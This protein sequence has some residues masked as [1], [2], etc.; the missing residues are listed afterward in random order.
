MRASV[1]RLPRNMQ[2]DLHVHL[3]VTVL[4]I[5][6]RNHLPQKITGKI[7]SLLF[8][9]SCIICI[10]FLLNKAT[11]GVKFGLFFP[12]YRVFFFLITNVTSVRLTR[13]FFFLFHSFSRHTSS[14]LSHTGTRPLWAISNLRIFSIHMQ[15]AL[16]IGALPP[17]L[18]RP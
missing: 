9:Y 4:D 15:I 13:M 16:I 18:S 7:I 14:L 5:L 11:P 10:S 1:E 8:C 12:P 2:M 3:G 17:H 6:P